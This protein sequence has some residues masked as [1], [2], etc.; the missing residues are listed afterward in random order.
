MLDALPSLDELARR[1]GTDKGGQRHNFARVYDGLLAGR[2]GDPIDLLEI[3]VYQ[4]ASLRMWEDYF[5]AARIWGIDI[6][7][8]AKEHESDRS[9]IFIGD[10]KDPELLGAILAASGGFDIIL[11]DGSH[12]IAEQRLSLAFLWPRL[13]PG[14]IYVLEDVHTSYLERWGMGYREPD[15]TLEM[16]KDILDDVHAGTHGRP[17]TLDQ[18]ASVHLYFELCVFQRRGREAPAI[19][20]AAD[21]T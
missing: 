19:G 7:P 8:S 13:R 9:R 14:G 11:D 6:N 4:G 20:L 15:T 1:H 21:A 2:R 16:V 10:Q 12:R 17:P 3:G 18:L 5:P